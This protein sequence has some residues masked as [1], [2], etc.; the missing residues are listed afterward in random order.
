VAVLDELGLKYQ[1]NIASGSG[2]E[3]YTGIIFQLYKGRE[4]IGGGGRYDALIPSM[5]G[6]DVPASGFALYLDSLM[7]FV[8]LGDNA[9]PPPRN[10]SVRIISA[11]AVKEAFELAGALRQ[12]GYTAEIDLDGG[13]KTD[14]RIIEVRSKSPVFTLVDK[15]K[16]KINAE[17]VDEVLKRLEGKSAG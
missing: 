12:A 10:I 11:G 4:K 2:F 16:L 8:K 15:N 14:K 6:G 17:S 3:Y 9:P 1:I 13:A 7:N 5:G